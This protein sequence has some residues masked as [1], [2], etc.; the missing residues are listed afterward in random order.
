VSFTA[1]DYESIKQA[2][3]VRLP[4]IDPSLVDME[5]RWTLY[6]F[7]METRVRIVVRDTPLVAGLQDYP[8]GDESV[9][10]ILEAKV[11]DTPIAVGRVQYSNTETGFPRSVGL[12]LDSLARVAPTPTSAESGKRLILTYA[13]TILPTNTTGELPLEA[14]PY[15]GYLLDGLLARVLAMPDKPWTNTRMAEPHLRRY[16]S[17]ISDVRR[18]IDAGRGYTSLTMRGPRFGV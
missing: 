5:M 2:A 6:E 1:A 3:M 16:R 14:K 18:M 13:T 4:G 12:V 8:M 9:V 7:L 15:H 17:G 10:V 11:D